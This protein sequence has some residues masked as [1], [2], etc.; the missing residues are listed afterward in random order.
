MQRT[1]NLIKNKPGR[2][3]QKFPYYSAM[4]RMYESNKSDVVTKQMKADIIASMERYEM[5]VLVEKE[6]VEDCIAFDSVP[7][8]KEFLD[9][10]FLEFEEG[11]SDIHSA[12][13]INLEQS[14]TFMSELMSDQFDEETEFG[15]ATILVDKR[16]EKHI[17]KDKGK[18]N[19]FLVWHKKIFLLKI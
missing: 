1:Y 9:E 10:E 3:P 15:S 2:Q 18:H 4:D 12:S 14:E 6:E 13:Q 8:E 7:V 5:E 16:R 11:N 17:K 19:L